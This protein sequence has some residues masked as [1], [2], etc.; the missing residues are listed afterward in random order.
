MLKR[1]SYTLAE[2]TRKME[3]YCAYQDRC[4]QEVLDKLRGMNMIPEAI[5]KVVVH[6]IENN[7][8]NEERFAKSFA[9]G[10]FRIK[11]W[12][13]I[14]ITSE[15]K[16]RN[17]SPFNIKSALKELDGSQY[18]ESL[19]S[20]AKKKA[21]SLKGLDKWTQKKKLTDYLLYRGWEQSLVYEL[22]NDLIP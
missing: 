10:K 7:Y 14:R 16:K 22:V 19:E 8:L 3:H 12:G 11:H 17:I 4:H 18:L 20:I 5:D 1:P 9:R 21:D 2:A 15:L 6:L 13:R